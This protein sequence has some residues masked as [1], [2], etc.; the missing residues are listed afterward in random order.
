MLAAVYSR[1]P[2]NRSVEIRSRSSARRWSVM[3]VPV[4]ITCVIAPASSTSRVAAHW[5]SRR[6]PSAVTQSISNS[7]GKS[8]GPMARNAVRADPA[9]SGGSSTSS[10]GRPMT[11]AA[12]R[13]VSR[14]QAW[15]KRWTRPSGPS[16]MT[17]AAAVSTPAVMM[18]RSACSASRA[19]ISAVT[20]EATPTNVRGAPCSSCSSVIVSE[21]RRRSP[22][23]RRNVHSRVSDPSRSG[24]VEN[25]STP[26]STPSSAARAAISSTS[27]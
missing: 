4:P 14:S 16:T 27:W 2:S 24:I 8:S 17:S 9:S 18:S 23:L 25:T 15:L 10:A 3:S 22:S 13:P 12:R 19:R 7:N 6:P 11:S 5:I 21:T 26:G 1:I 20:S